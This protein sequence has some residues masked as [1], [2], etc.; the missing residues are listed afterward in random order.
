[1]TVITVEKNSQVRPDEIIT[2]LEELNIESRPVGKPMHLQPVFA[3]CDYFKNEADIS[4]DIFANGICLPSGTAMSEEQQ[5]FI[6][7]N[8]QELFL[9]MFGAPLT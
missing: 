9:V 3:N 1:M 4:A 8:I 6:I 2:K 5:E 7:S